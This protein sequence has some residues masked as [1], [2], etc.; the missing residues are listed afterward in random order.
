[1]LELTSEWGMLGGPKIRSQ[2]GYLEPCRPQ[3][4]RCN[5]LSSQSTIVAAMAMHQS[6]SKEKYNENW[7]PRNACF[8]KFQVGHACQVVSLPARGSKA[9]KCCSERKLSAASVVVEHCLSSWLDNLSGCLY[10][11]DATP[12]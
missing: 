12:G 4:V 7:L 6:L 2:G 9:S 1:M 3:R 8:E 11:P 10:R 5:S